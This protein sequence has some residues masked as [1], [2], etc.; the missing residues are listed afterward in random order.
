LIAI[1]RGARGIALCVAGL[2]A[3]S[4]GSSGNSTATPAPSPTSATAPSPFAFEALTHVSW[5]HDGYS[6]SD[7]QDARRALV[8]SHAH[9]VGLLATWYMDTR[10]SN[11]ITPDPLQTPTDDTVTQTIQELHSLGFKVMLKPHVDVKDGSWRGTIHPSDTSLWFSN[12]DAFLNHYAGIAHATSV[13][14]LNVG[15]ELATMSDSR[16]AGAWTE[17]IGHVRATFPGPLTYGANAN[18]PGDEFT[19]V[20]FWNLL[21]YAGLDVYAPL[22]SH[23]DPTVAELTSAWSSNLN[24]DDMLGAYRNWQSGHGKPV[25]FT[26]IG[27]RSIAG[28]NKAP[29]DFTITGP[30]DVTEQANCYEAALGVWS[31]ESSWLKGVFFWAWPTNPPQAGDTDYTPRDKPAEAVLQKYFTP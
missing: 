23:A 24:G 19:S 6:G 26:E 15:T 13:E 14:L 21:D 18:A 1:A 28:A 5:W 31:K 8:A 7:A 17:V 22:T 27:Y 16:N 12:Y 4:C 10:D 9:W 25:L 20:S 29:W 2:V 11:G 3:V 30:A